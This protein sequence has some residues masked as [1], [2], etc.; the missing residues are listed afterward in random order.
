MANITEEPG[1]G[2]SPA[3]WIAVV[4][5]L[6]GIAVGTLFLFL[7]VL[8]MVYVGAVIVVV[9]LL[10]GWVLKKAGFGVNGSRLRS[11]H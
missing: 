2:S 9:G 8:P 1:H 6:F 3:A 5:M 10:V 4:I 11:S 7:D